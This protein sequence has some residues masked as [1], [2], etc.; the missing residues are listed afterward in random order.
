MKSGSLKGIQKQFELLEIIEILQ[1]RND[2]QSSP[3]IDHVWTI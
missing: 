3:M 1:N 2:E